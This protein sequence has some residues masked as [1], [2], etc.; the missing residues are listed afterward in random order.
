[1]T[2]VYH[3]AYRCDLNVMYLGTHF[4]NNST[5]TF[6]FSVE[7]DHFLSLLY[8]FMLDVRTT[9]FTCVDQGAAFCAIKHLICEKP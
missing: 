5:T 7:K 3:V 6:M 4:V 2:S 9:D 8:V 1:M